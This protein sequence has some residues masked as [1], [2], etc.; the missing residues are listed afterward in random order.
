VS[1]LLITGAAGYIGSHVAVELLQAG[2]DVVV[3][4]DLSAGHADALVR[5]G[6]LGGTP[7]DFVLGRVEDPDALDRALT[8]FGPVD[9]VLHFAALKSVPESVAQP[10]RYWSV[11]VGGTQALCEAMV[12]H[13]VRRAVFSSTAAIYGSDAPMPVD[14]AA[15]VEP[16][17]PY[18]RTK[19]AAEGIFRDAAAAHGWQVL[20]LR[21][22]NPVGAHP[23][24]RIGEDQ[25]RP[26]NLAPI[27]LGVAL[28]ERDGLVVHGTDYDTPDG[29]AVRDF[30]H[31]LDLATCHRLAVEGLPKLGDGDVRVYNI[32]TGRGSSVLELIA[33]AERACGHAIPY[34]VGQR[35]PG[36]LPAVVADP[37]R[38][39]ADF[40][41]RPQR[42]LDSMLA[43][44]WAWS[45]AQRRKPWRR[46]DG[47]LADLTMDDD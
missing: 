9:A 7:V 25:E 16:E 36:D 24:G 15:P 18:G 33:A 45:L 39:E 3:L 41:F 34:S 26:A 4:D 12:R 10:L 30:L 43:D 31:V 44:A 46:G 20:L 22:F 38:F 40:G 2:H 1:R 27:V 19:L 17:S 11:N 47:A 6:Q 29:T 35:R 28:G 23:S 42:D 37:R 14:E 32:G 8:E 21:Y 13:D 5:A